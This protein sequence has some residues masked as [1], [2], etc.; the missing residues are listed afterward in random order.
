MR[1]KAEETRKEQEEKRRM[2]LK[3]KMAL[4]KREKEEK[5]EKKRKE[6]ERKISSLYERILLKGKGIF[7]SAIPS[8]RWSKIFTLICYNFGQ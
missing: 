4:E 5:E 8:L 1:R 3:N 7:S 2:N 6:E